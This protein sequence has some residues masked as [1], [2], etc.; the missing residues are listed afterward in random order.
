[1][2]KININVT[3][4]FEKDLQ[5]LMRLRKFRTKTEAIRVAV[6]EAAQPKA[7]KDFS[8]FEEL[9]GAGL[10]GTLNPN[11]RFKNQDDLWS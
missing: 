2:R 10:R 6:H 8:A 9:L 4:E 3:P 7:R 11:P 1:M 5:R